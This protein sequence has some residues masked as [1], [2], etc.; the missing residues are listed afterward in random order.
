[1]NDS[2]FGRLLGVLVSPVR[3]FRALAR[4]PTWAAALLV[5]T[6]SAGAAGVVATPRIDYEDLIR[7]SVAKSGREIPAEQ[8]DRQIEM[9]KKI[10]IP[11]TVAGVLIAPLVV[12][13]F[14]LFLFIGFKLLGSDLG[15]RQ[16][17]SVMIHAL[18]PQVIA[19]LLS[20]PVILSRPVWGYQALRAGSYLASNLAALVGSPETRETVFALL[21][22][23][24]FFV[25]WTLILLVLGFRE[26]ARVSTAKATA[27]ILVLWLLYVGL[28]VGRAALFG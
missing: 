20:I 2:A 12:C 6:L 15:Y 24:D 26:V 7:H 10:R 1:M 16:S 14:A 8:L 5:F 9:M 3:T 18:M 13:L 4:N 17:L 27:T 23:I 25:L 22:S 19:N 11:L 21:A 28:K